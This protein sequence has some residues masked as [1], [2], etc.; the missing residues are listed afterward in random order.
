MANN[1]NQTRW[2]SNPGL[3]DVQKF[4]D[5]HSLSTPRPTVKVNLSIKDI[6]QAALEPIFAML[7][8][9]GVDFGVTATAVYE[10]GRQM[11][12]WENRERQQ[13]PVA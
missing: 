4:I 2:A 12:F 11:A 5:Q 6:P 13:A 8:E 9:H 10:P 7:G 3:P 1:H